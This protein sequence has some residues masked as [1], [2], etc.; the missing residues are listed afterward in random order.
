MVLDTWGSWTG[1]RNWH[2]VKKVL[3]MCFRVYGTRTLRP[4]TPSIFGCHKEI[5]FEYRS[6]PSRGIVLVILAL[7]L[8]GRWMRTRTKRRQV[9]IFPTTIMP[10]TTDTP[11]LLLCNLT[12]RSIP[13]DVRRRVSRT[14]EV[15]MSKRYARNQDKAAAKFGIHP[16]PFSR[17]IREGA[18]GTRNTSA[19]QSRAISSSVSVS[20]CT[21]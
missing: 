9:D 14:T 10:S 18:P 8:P 5:S 1:R 2:G 19:S 16:S 20:C 3:W 6:A 21:A 7:E 11:P 12:D 15:T 17:W 4:Q 13:S